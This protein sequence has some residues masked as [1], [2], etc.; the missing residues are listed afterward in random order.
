MANQTTQRSWFA[1]GLGAGVVAVFCLTAVVVAWAL[2][3]PRHDPVGGWLSGIG[4]GWSAVAGWYGGDP[5]AADPNWQ[6]MA[7]QVQ[8][9][10]AA[11]GQIVFATYGCGACHVIPGVSGARGTVGPSLA[12]FAN[13]AY[14]GGVLGNMPGNLTR[15]L[16]NPPLFSPDTAMPDL[17]V[18]QADAADMAAYLYT[19]G[20]DG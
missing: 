10:A 2:A 18:G 17:G 14:V 19:L 4:R 5:V 1:L 7:L 15:W 13:R 12:G 3:S 20:R 6:A 9:G 11:R 8:G 16:I